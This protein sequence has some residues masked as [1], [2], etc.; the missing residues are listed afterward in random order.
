M[1]Y[2]LKEMNKMD[3]S[4]KELRWNVINEVD[5]VTREELRLSDYVMVCCKPIGEVKDMRFP[6]GAPNK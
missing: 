3:Y 5:N 6:G 2:D 4:V 1:D